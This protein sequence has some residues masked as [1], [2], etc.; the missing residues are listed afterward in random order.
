MQTQQQTWV[1][2]TGLATLGYRGEHLN[3]PHRSVYSII[4]NDSK[5]T[6]VVYRCNAKSVNIKLIHKIYSM[7]VIIINIIRRVNTFVQHCMSQCT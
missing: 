1:A 6:K 4:V 7:S 2:L 3:H 5:Q